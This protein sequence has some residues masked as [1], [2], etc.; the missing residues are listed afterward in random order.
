MFEWKRNNIIY[1]LVFYPKKVNRSRRAAK[2]LVPE[3]SMQNT[4]GVINRNVIEVNNNRWLLIECTN[5][6]TFYNTLN[7]GQTFNSKILLYSCDFIRKLFC[8]M[9]NVN[10]SVESIANINELWSIEWKIA[11]QHTFYNIPY[12]SLFYVCLFSYCSVIVW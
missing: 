8:A 6:N 2:Q 7:F 9:R 5:K 3:F 4:I 1:L 11:N 10:C 12:R